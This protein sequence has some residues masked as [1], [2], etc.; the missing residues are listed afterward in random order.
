MPPTAALS[1]CSSTTPLSPDPTP[2][3]PYYPAPDPSP[4]LRPDVLHVL[5]TPD[6]GRIDPADIARCYGREFPPVHPSRP[7]P[8][9]SRQ[10]LTSRRPRTPQRRALI[11][12]HTC[13]NT[14]TIGADRLLVLPRSDHFQP[15]G[16]IQ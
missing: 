4:W 9:P 7:S 10:P 15:V 5:T 12:A 2:P 6:G 11:S 8:T 14:A 1:T 13:S 3:S 16:E